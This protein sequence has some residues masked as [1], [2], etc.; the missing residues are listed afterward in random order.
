MKL[1]KESKIATL[2]CPFY[3]IGASVC[4]MPA[5][6]GF[7][8]AMDLPHWSMRMVQYPRTATAIKNGQKSGHI[9]HHFF[10]FC[11]PGSHWG[12]TDQLVAQLWC[13]VAL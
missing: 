13:L 12:N 3:N 1:L 8:K 6:C 10:V 4:P 7:M 11:R 9:L 5:C 2:Q